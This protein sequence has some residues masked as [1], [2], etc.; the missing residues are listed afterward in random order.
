[1]LQPYPARGAFPADDEAEAELAWVQGF[2]LG[3]RQIRGEM[4]I[5]PSK[6][7]PVLLQDASAED[8]RSLET[9]TARICRQLVRI[10]SIAYSTVGGS[11]P[12]LRHR[13]AG[14]HEDP[15]AD[16]RPD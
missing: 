4:D 16:G 3:I 8:R 7:L 11:R 5:A 2:V 10:E 6:P 1:M 9:H 12:G 13:A 15:G 14:R